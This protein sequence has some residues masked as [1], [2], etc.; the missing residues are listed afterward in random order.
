MLLCLLSLNWLKS[1][2]SFNVAVVT[3][4]VAVVPLKLLL[5]KSVGPVSK[6]AISRTFTVASCIT[7]NVANAIDI[8]AADIAVRIVDVAGV[9]YVILRFLMLMLL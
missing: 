4:H 5:M 8:S 6:I 3:T 7:I 1:I 2:V 9:F